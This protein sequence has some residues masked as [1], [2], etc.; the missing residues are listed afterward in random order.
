VS[1]RKLLTY[2]F[3][4]PKLDD[5]NR[6]KRMIKPLALLL[7]IAAF[8]AIQAIPATGETFNVSTLSGKGGIGQFARPSGLAISP[9]GTVYV[10]DTDSFKIKKIVGQT[11]SDFVVSPATSRIHTD[12][13]FCGVFVKNADEIFA[14]DC[15]NFKVYK[16][17]KSGLLLRTYTNTLDL[18]NCKNCFD[19]GGGLAVDKLGGIFLSDEH[20]HVIIRIDENSGDSSVYVGQ[21]G[22]NSS[23]DGNFVNATFNL[24]RGLTVDSKNNLYIADTWSNSVRK[25]DPSRTTS[26]IERG[27]TCLMGVAVNS[28][29]DVFTV[30]ERYC[31]PTIFKVGTGKIFEDT[32]AL[33]SG[34]PG[35]AGKPAFSGSSGISIE[36][37]GSNP[38]N[39]IYIA[40]WA[41]HSIKIFSKSGQLL[42]TI[43]SEDSYGVNYSEQSTP[44]FDSPLQVFP[45]D[46]GSYLVVDNHTIRHLNSNGAVLR[47]TPTPNSCWFSAGV[48]FTSD[49]TFFCTTGHKIYVR[50]TDG[51]WSTIGSDVAGKRDGNSTSV[52]FFR[53]EGLSIYNNELYVA[54]NGNRQIRKLTRIAG[55]RE[56]QVSTVL[57]T[58][59]WTGAPDIQPRSKA[60]FAG[61]TKIAIDGLGNL[62]IVDGGVDSV[63]KTSLVQENDVTRIAT[64]LKDWPSAITVDKQNR[65]YVSTYGGTFFRITNNVMSKI[66]GIQGYGNQ[67]GS[68]ERALFNRP[69]GLSIDAKGD[70]LVADRDNQKIRKVN[71]GTT[72][73]LNILSA[74]SVGTYLKQSESNQPIL[75]GLSQAQEAALEENLIKNNNSGLIAKIYQSK[76]VAIP[77]RSTAGL[78]LCEVK[79]EK[80]ISFDWA[81]TA[82]SSANG[83]GVRDYIVTYK[84]YITWPGEGVQPR[85]LYAAVDDGM[86][87]KINNETVIDKWSD[88]GANSNYPFNKSAIA[89]LEG[90]KQYPIEIWYYAWTPPSNFKL[91]WSPISA[92]QRDDTRLVEPEVFS[93]KLLNTNQSKPIITKPAR[94]F[95]PKVSINLNFINLT[96]SVP[97]GTKSALLFAPEFGVPKSKA[98]VGQI[99]DSKAN[100]EI[101]INDRYAGK[102][103]T[104]QIVSK[105]EVGESSPL[106]LPVTG[107]KV[108]SKPVAVKTLAPKPVTRA[109]EITCLKGA[110]KR[111]FQALDCPPGYTK[112]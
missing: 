76:D 73:G 22:K 72:P 111:T 27:L 5:V 89:T 87:L 106:N 99:S 100:F 32:N 6:Y 58:G 60:T 77:V 63:F 10:A 62:Y 39:N 31:A 49:G 12:N 65:V 92:N 83:C 29:D 43:G 1:G 54:D 68:F 78:P 21:V 110:T 8:P 15:R 96:V 88:G 38:T 46:D 75:Q 70:L 66:G 71:I 55:T 50:Y 107:P 61:P 56:F 11:V 97:L 35:Y 28:N 74:S 30:N 4:L 85:V 20:N 24:P 34:T 57:G 25:V 45:V 33:K 44:V 53:P 95:A 69:T 41:N 101:S 18:P 93:P 3:E 82:L 104:L 67:D 17:N 103:G 52:Q 98:I 108:K 84:G 13:S 16:Y 2:T 36:R 47:V 42:R 19:W 48:A 14:S 9:D 91:Y 81:Y 90:G 40:D 7:I 112:G 79:I 109:Q 26:T 80:Q 37:F 64:G 23:V 51:T 59:V 94:P 86:H 105:N 102:K